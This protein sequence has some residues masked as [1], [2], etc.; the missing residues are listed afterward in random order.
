[1]AAQQLSALAQHDGM[2]TELSAVTRRKARP[3]KAPE[4]NDLV[5]FSYPTHGFSLPWR[6]LK[7]ILAY[8]RGRARIFL[9]NNR[10]G[11]KFSRVFTPGV[12]GIAVL[13]PL[14]ILCIKGYRPAGALPLD[15]PSNWVV[16]HPGLSPRTVHAIME[17]RKRDLHKLWQKVTAGKRRFPTKFWIM[18]PL[19]ILVAP[20]SVAYLAFG[21]FILTATYTADT[22]CD[23]C[24]LCARQCPVG[25]I[26]VVHG[27]PRWSIRCESCMRCLNVCPQKAV[28]GSWLLMGLFT[29]ALLRLTAFSGPLGFA[30]KSLSR[31]GGEAASLLL[32][33]A[34]WLLAVFVAW[35][36]GHLL[37]HLNRWKPAARFLAVTTPMHFWRRY[38][39]PA[40]HPERNGRGP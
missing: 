13:L 22:S 27:K 28:H 25:A 32:Y 1:L 18:I 2:E 9:I 15:T 7:F 8:P 24:G 16:V 12:S 37:F 34:W 29:W 33:P 6:M 19:D 23:G 21:C 3:A 14:L 31:R 5:V 11:M 39:N 10:A 38:L 20:I 4:R 30:W 40:F 35:M 36:L 26:R 17:R